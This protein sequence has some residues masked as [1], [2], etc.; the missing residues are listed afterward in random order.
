[1]NSLAK[2]LAGKARIGWLDWLAIYRLFRRHFRKEAAP[3][4]LSVRKFINALMGMVDKS[5]G[6]GSA[7]RKTYRTLM[8]AGMHFQDRYNFDVERVKRCAIPY[9]TLEGIFPFCTYNSGPTYRT[10]VEQIHSCT[11]E[12]YQQAHDQ[13]QG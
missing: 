10:F 1:M 6:R 9:S 5:K 4:D 12:A 13:R 7:G 8:A 2:R 11:L 3:R